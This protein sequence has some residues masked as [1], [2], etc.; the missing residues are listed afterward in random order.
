[1]SERDWRRPQP[2]EPEIIPPDRPGRRPSGA[3]PIFFTVESGQRRRVFSMP[4]SPVT[5]LF[6][7]L[8]IGGIAVATLFLLLGAFAIGAVAVGL[9]L[10]GFMVSGLV[11]GLLRRLS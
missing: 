2:P 4:P 8:V 3:P 1:M 9:I 10:A 11:R 7:G 5:T 6:A